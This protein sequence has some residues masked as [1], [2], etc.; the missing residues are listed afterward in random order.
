MSENKPKKNWVLIVI[1][2][3]VIVLNAALILFLILNPMTLGWW[4]LLIGLSAV[5]SISLSLKAI[6]ENEPAWLMI[7]LI[8]PK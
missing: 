7:D 3:T 2:S 8:L 6:K 1:A 4:T 5:V